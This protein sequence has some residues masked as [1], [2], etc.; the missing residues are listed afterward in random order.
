MLEI[1]NIG[2]YIKIDI[3]GLALIKILIRK[4]I[5]NYSNVNDKSVRESY[6]VLAGVVGIISNLFLFLFKLAAG[7][8]INSIA[9]ISDAFNNLTDL[10]SSLVS[11]IG[12]KLSNIPPD[13]EHPHGHGRFEYIST[14]VVSFIIFSV[15]LQLLRSSFDKIINPEEVLFSLMSIIILIISVG[16]KLWMFSYNK[17]IGKTINSS[18]IKATASD[19]LNDAIATSAVIAT[20]IIGNYIS[21]PIDGIV[22]V[23]ISILILYTGFSI[24]KET[25]NLL[26]GSS[27]DPVLIEIINS[28]VMQ[29]E[30]V[31]GTH[32]LKVHDYGPGRVIASIH[33]E[34]PDN[35]S[36]VEIHCIIDELEKNIADELGINIVI[37]MDP[38]STDVDRI[39]VVTKSINS[40]IAEIN[41]SFSVQNLR[42][43]DGIDRINVV[44]DLLVPPS[45]TQ[46]EY[47]YITKLIS[48][49]AIEYN[50]KFNIV[51]NTI[52]VN[53]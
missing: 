29:G 15:G 53:N 3:G 27:P 45:I 43:T 26:L 21:F 52:S 9:V 8:F 22:G 32:D 35:I 1:K 33:A 28:M 31:V 46:S 25:V 18:I 6:G 44:F 39:N 12:A 40:V 17:Y 5:K 38:I 50:S 47:E 4:F 36:I 34:V 11:I 48:E 23:I 51:I 41:K 37:H 13:N 49:K 20:T 24:A 30:H 42:I 19:S 7:I 2:N 10:G 16:V 14:L